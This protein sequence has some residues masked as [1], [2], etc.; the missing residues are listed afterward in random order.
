MLEDLFPGL[1]GSDWRVTSPADRR[2]NCIAWA[3]GDSQH[4]WWPDADRVDC[5][6]RDVVRSNHIDQ[7]L[8]FL[9]RQRFAPCI[10]DSYKAPIEKIALYGANNRVR[11][12]ARQVGPHRWTSKIGR[13]EDIEHNLAALEGDEY[14]RVLLLMRREKP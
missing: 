6:P 11:H 14:G 5:W 12:A 7:L 2:Y 13:L 4:V 9:E 8:L 10:D 1:I 3:I